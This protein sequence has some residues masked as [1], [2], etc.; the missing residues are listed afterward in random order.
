LIPAFV[1]CSSLP[2]RQ[3]LTPRAVV[4]A[5]SSGDVRE[6]V[7]RLRSSQGVSRG[8]GTDSASFERGLVSVVV[9]TLNE[10]SYLGRLLDSL[11][12]QHVPAHEVIVVD[13]GSTDGTVAIARAHGARTLIFPG[14][15]EYPSRNHG[16]AAARGD[17]LLFTGADAVFPASLIDNV[18]AGFSSDPDLVAL[19]GPGVPIRPPVLLGMEYKVYN[20]VRWAL[21]RLPY[22][23]K[24]FICSANLLAV[25]AES[26]LSCGLFGEDI[27]ADGRLGARLCLS[28]PT[29]FCYLKVRGH[30][31]SRRLWGMGF[32]GFNRHFLYVLENFIPQASEWQLIRDQ[33]AM[34]ALVHSD[35]RVA[36]GGGD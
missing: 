13:G 9:P 5:L 25:T 17:I 34:S 28:G 18:I 14:E 29:R 19:A 11:E 20:L 3:R 15:R 8:C 33:K 10:A 16:A 30:I 24:R 27:N 36:V 7:H 22:P 1:L 23:W 2:R 21:S 4:A 26:F 31:S 12:H 35:M 32:L 6:G